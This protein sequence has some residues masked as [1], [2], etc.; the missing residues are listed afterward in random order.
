MKQKLQKNIG[1]D[2]I[3]TFITNLNMQSSI[4]VLYLAYCGMNLA[5][6]GLLEGVYHATSIICEIPSGA[7]ADF[8]NHKNVSWNLKRRRKCECI[9]ALSLLYLRKSF[10]YFHFFIYLL[11]EFI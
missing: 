10:I 8:R 4:W 6:I 7:F 5:Q 9:Y 3:A 1:L 11:C 2:Y